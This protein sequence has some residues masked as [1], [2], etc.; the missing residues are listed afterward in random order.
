MP[1]ETALDYYA[2]EYG[3]IPQMPTQELWD[4]ALA[5]MHNRA[6]QKFGQEAAAEGWMRLMRNKGITITKAQF[7]SRITSPAS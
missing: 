6:I 3:R 4:R 1:T 7:C 2:A 5:H